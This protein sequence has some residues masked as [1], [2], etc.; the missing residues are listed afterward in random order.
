M[1]K[2]FNMILVGVVLAIS[3]LSFAKYVLISVE[4]IPLVV[5]D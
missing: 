1:S 4:P 3:S 2:I 5:S